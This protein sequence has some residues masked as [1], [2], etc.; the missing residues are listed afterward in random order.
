MKLTLNRLRALK[1]HYTKTILN[2]AVTDYTDVYYVAITLIGA[3][4]G[5]IIMGAIIY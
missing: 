4:I 3:V 5:I 1:R 2:K